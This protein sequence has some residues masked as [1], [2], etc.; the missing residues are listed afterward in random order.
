[1]AGPG[2]RSRRAAVKVHSLALC[3]LGGHF[4]TGA[5][6]G[7]CRIWEKIEDGDV[8]LVDSRT[9]KSAFDWS[10]EGSA[11]TDEAQKRRSGKSARLV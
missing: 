4:A 10:G 8:E 1:M 11:P 9:T 7:I 3:P 6:D 2:T 5:T